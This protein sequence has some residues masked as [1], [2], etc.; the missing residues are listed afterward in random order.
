MIF[1]KIHSMKF[2][3][4][5][6]FIT[7]FAFVP[8]CRPAAAPV[9]VSNRPVS[10]NGV[11][12]KDAQAKPLKPVR[13]MSWTAFDGSVQKVKDFQGKVVV[14]DFWATFCPPCI[15]EIPHL[16]ALQAK[17]GEADLVIIGLN[18]GGDEDR[19]KIPEFAERLKIAYP[20]AY[21]EDAL[22]A[23]IFGADD[24]IPQTVV[25]DRQGRLVKKIVG[26]NGEIKTELDDAVEAAVNSK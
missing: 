4:V 19:P 17:Y 15:E 13:E 11:P 23:F 6:L 9:A 3:L 25:F 21:P 14:A 8:A 16:N 7:A 18:V 26:F 20:L 24:S 12:L 5:C 22:T 2:F 1:C 10:V